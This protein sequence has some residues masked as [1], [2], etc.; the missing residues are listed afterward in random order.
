MQNSEICNLKSALCIPV[1]VLDH[2]LQEAGGFS[3]SRHIR[4]TAIMTAAMM[5]PIVMQ[6]QRPMSRDRWTGIN[7]IAPLID[8]RRELN[9]TSRQLVQLDS[10]ERV[11]LAR[12]QG[13]RDQLRV[14]LDSVRPRGGTRSEEEIAAM[15]AQGDSLRALQRVIARNDSVARVSAMAVLSD[16][17]RVRVRERVAERRGFEAGRQS[18]MREGRRPGSPEFNDQMGPRMR[19]RMGGMGMGLGMENP[20]MR[21][22][23]MGGPRMG[24][25][26]MGA[27]GMR[28]RGAPPNDSGPRRFRRPPPPPEQLPG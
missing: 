2:T 13:I 24:G 20:G 8:M 10:I 25:P 26:G 6:A 16:S 19:G 21:G 28:F 11:L 15:R 22:P 5:L 27:P 1:S 3:M 23:G 4:R 14:R 17:Q 7:S 12:N 18:R 9:L